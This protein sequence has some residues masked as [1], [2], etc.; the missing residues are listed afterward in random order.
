MKR[1]LLLELEAED[2]ESLFEP[3]GTIYPEKIDVSDVDT[4]T[5]STRARPSVD[6]SRGEFLET[7][8]F[9]D[10]SEAFEQ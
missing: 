1:N 3:R 4:L 8:E 9:K 2:F 7:L 10:G 6:G 5:I